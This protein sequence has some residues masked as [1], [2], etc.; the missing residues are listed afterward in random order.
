MKLN[1][2]SKALASCLSGAN[3]LDCA[4]ILYT[5]DTAPEINSAI[6][7]SNI[8]NICD[9]NKGVVRSKSVAVSSTTANSID[10]LISSRQTETVGAGALNFS[11]GVKIYG[12]ILATS[13][14]RRAGTIYPD[15]LFFSY[16]KLDEPVVL[17]AGGD[18]GV[19]VT[20]SLGGN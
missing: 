18:I 11:A 7:S 17:P 13:S 14:Y 3:K 2:Y 10:I 19:T 9:S 16:H 20:L 8:V 4:Y 1:T 5:N 12:V 6:D 15:D